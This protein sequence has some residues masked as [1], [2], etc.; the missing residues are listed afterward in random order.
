VAQIW[1]SRS[2]LIRVFILTLRALKR[3]AGRTLLLFLGIL[4]NRNRIR[5][6][7]DR[8]ACWVAVCRGL[9]DGGA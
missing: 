7:S 8:A 6:L 9:L 4:N 1:Q 2:I 3:V 5:W